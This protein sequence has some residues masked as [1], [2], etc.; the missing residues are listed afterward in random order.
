MGN[1]MCGTAMGLCYLFGLVENITNFL[2]E[3]GLPVRFAELE[4]PTFLPGIEIQAGGLVIDRARLLYPGD[5]LHEAGH[6]ALMDPLRRSQTN[7]DAGPDAGAEIGAIAWSYAAA[8]HIGIDARVVFHPD[9]YKGAAAS[10]ANN[11]ISGYY[12]GVPMLQWKGL[13][14][15]P[16]IARE[17]GLAPYPRM[18]RWLCE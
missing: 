3:I 17:R 15:E 16:R 4:H 5:I 11:F 1:F 18:L 7:G 8:V 14:L 2:A 10:I 13:A 9:G 12:M 6:L